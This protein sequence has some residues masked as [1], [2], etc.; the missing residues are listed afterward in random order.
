MSKPGVLVN[1]VQVSRDG[2]QDGYTYVIPYKAFTRKHVSM[3]GIRRLPDASMPG[4]Q[5]WQGFHD[6]FLFPLYA[7]IYELKGSSME[8][9]VSFCASAVAELGGIRLDA[10]ATKT[11][12]VVCATVILYCREH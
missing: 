5:E 3:S 10:T 8:A 6:T 2:P 11:K 9:P 12:M 1:V 4:A 7:K